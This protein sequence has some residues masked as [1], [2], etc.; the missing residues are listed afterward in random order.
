MPVLEV[1]WSTQA[2]HPQKYEWRRTFYFWL[3]LELTR[4]FLGCL[5][6]LSF[7]KEMLVGFIL[8]QK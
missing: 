6:Y 5:E 8:Y 2:S 4:T 7:D 3:Q 1:V